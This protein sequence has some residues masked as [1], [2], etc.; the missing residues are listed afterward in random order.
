MT[1]SLILNDR[2]IPRSQVGALPNLPPSVAIVYP[3]E[4]APWEVET[5]RTRSQRWFGKNRACYA[6]DLSDHRRS[7]KLTETPLTCQDGGH[8]FEAKID[9]GFRVHDPVRLVRGNVQDALSVIYGC[10]THQMRL[11]A[12]EFPITEALAAQTRMNGAF[13]QDMQLTEGITIY[14][15]TIQLEPDAASREFIRRLRQAEREDALGLHSNK[16]AVGQAWHTESIKDIEHQARIA[17]EEQ[18]R[19][20]LAGVQLDFESLV[21][22]HLTKHPN[23]TQEA[24]GLL[25]RLEES[26]AGQVEIQEQRHVEMVKYLIDKGVVRDVDLPGVRNGVLGAGVAGVL[27]PSGQ[28]SAPGPAPAIGPGR[29]AAGA[30]GHLAGTQGGGAPSAIPQSRSAPVRTW[31]DAGAQPATPAAGAPAT[32]LVPVYVVL[33][34]SAAAAGCATELANALRS[35]QTLLANSPDVAAAVRLS[36]LSYAD[37]AEVLLPLTEVTWQ[38]GI[39]DLRGGPGCRY[40]PAFRRL[41]DLVPLETERLKQQVARVL[42]PVVF[43]LAVGE[44]EDAPQWGDVRAELMRHKYHPHLVACGIG[45]VRGHTVERLAS[46]PELGVVA[47]PGADLAQSAVQFSVLLQNTVLH[48][49][50][51]ALAGGMELRLDCPQGLTPVKNVQ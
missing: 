33:D 51:S 15:C 34:A 48:L 42:R 29:H 49:G 2:P 38:T 21:R 19:K 7:A 8:R 40:A 27:S 32:G 23:D 17:R 24:M 45:D 50:R 46:R 43:L 14:H 10:L 28:A 41:L 36:V 16:A 31:G 35:L 9:V 26:R 18:E 4:G 5:V 13:A 1:V 30:H 39:P 25:L 12:A 44:A 47:L 20:V 22:E 3:V 11:Y 6:V 37:T